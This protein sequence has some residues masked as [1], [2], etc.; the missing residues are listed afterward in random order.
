MEPRPKDVKFNIYIFLEGPI[1]ENYI[2][3]Y[4]NFKT[5]TKTFLEHEGVK[6]SFICHFVGEQIIEHVNEQYSK[7]IYMCVW[8]SSIR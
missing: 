1:I 8:H 3:F 5:K 4:I 2:Y 7:I 6:W